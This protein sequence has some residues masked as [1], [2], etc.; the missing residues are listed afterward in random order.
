MQGKNPQFSWTTKTCQWTLQKALMDFPFCSWTVRSA[1]KSH[2]GEISALQ[3]TTL[4][5]PKCSVTVKAEFLLVFPCSHWA[6]VSLHLIGGFV[7]WAVNN[8]PKQN[9]HQTLCTLYSRGKLL[10]CT[11]QVAVRNHCSSPKRNG[12][13]QL[14]SRHPSHHQSAT[15]QDETVIF[16][17]LLLIQVPVESKALR[18]KWTVQ[19]F[20]F[21]RRIL[22]MTPSLL[23]W[24]ALTIKFQRVT[25]RRAQPSARVSEDI[26]LPERGSPKA[27]RIKATQPHFPHFPRSRVRIFRIFRP[28]SLLRPLCFCRVRGDFRIF[29][30]P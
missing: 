8:H 26:C 12:H 9:C 28:W 7:L 25:I 5:V 14:V 21:G 6:Y 3:L 20:G 24:C 30:V 22:C 2:F 19:I 23:L 17:R 1:E 18:T 16:N 10:R 11:E 27:N 4:K 13:K 29:P 15:D